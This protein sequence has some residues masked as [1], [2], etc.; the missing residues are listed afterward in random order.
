M[1]LSSF[2]S[3]LRRTLLLLLGSMFFASQ[4]FAQD[5]S[6]SIT[7]LPPYPAE[8]DYY[9]NNSDNLSIELKNNTGRTIELYAGASLSSDGGV[10]VAS[11]SGVRPSMPISLSPFEFRVITGSML[12]ELGMEVSYPDDFDISGISEAERNK[13]IADRVVPEDNYRLCIQLYNWDTDALILESCSQDFEIIYAQP[14]VILTP[15]NNSSYDDIAQP[16]FVQWSPVRPGTEDLGEVEYAIQIIEIEKKTLDFGQEYVQLI[17]KSRTNVVYEMEGLTGLSEVIDFQDFESL[18][19][20]TKDEIV[21]AMQV[22]AKDVEN[23]SRILNEGGSNLIVFGIENVDDVDPIVTEPTNP[24]LTAPVPGTHFYTYNNESITIEWEYEAPEDDQIHYQYWIMDYT[25]LYEQGQTM[26]EMLDG[27]DI[28]SSEAYDRAVY[29]YDEWDVEEHE[30]VPGADW[31]LDE[32][33]FEEGHYYILCFWVHNKEHSAIFADSAIDYFEFAD[34]HYGRQEI[35]DPLLSIEDTVTSYFP[36]LSWTEE[37]IIGTDME[38]AM[39]VADFT[40]EYEAGQTYEQM[41]ASFQNPWDHAYVISDQSIVGKTSRNIPSGYLKTGHYYL[42]LFTA[43]DKNGVVRF[44]SSQEA[45][46]SLH[47]GF[48]FLP[49]GNFRPPTITSPEKGGYYLSYNDDP[50][51]VSWDFEPPASAQ[52]QY[53]VFIYDYTDAFAAGQS[54]E[55]I[56]AS[57]DVNDEDSF[58]RLLYTEEVK[59]ENFLDIEAEDKGWVFAARDWFEEGTHYVLWFAAYDANYDNPISFTGGESMASQ[60]THFHYGTSNLS[61]P[62]LT[63]A[64]TVWGNTIP[65]SWTNI[66]VSGTAMEYGIWIADFTTEQ[67]SGMSLESIQQMMEQQAA[68]ITY[69]NA[70]ISDQNTLNLVAAE[71]GFE[72]GHYYLIMHSSLDANGVLNFQSTNSSQSYQFA[73]FQYGIE[74][75]LGDPVIYYP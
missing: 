71:E 69:E 31:F 73:G 32:P 33:W 68:S 50:F 21:Y 44:V 10:Q 9:L 52:M 29:G 58:D 19:S 47:E 48:Y 14:P 16:M 66:D 39:W 55:Q 63:V 72:M 15:D 30:I 18:R 36:Q 25:D 24:K 42:I 13:I 8:A 74:D 12:D 1:Q 7:V 26:E 2:H 23:E 40:T 57:F 54:F 61:D 67:V 46:T 5:V 11:K 43:L 35:D 4:I 41:V 70:K 28:L 3:S 53:K 59:G 17:I 22:I 6:V 56:E 62:V 60:L 49:S 20:V 75:G 34:F 27:F 64:D 38:Y 51:R 37:N 65:I 45:S